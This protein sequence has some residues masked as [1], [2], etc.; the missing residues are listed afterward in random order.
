MFRNGPPLMR[1]SSPGVSRMRIGE[2]SRQYKR[3]RLSVAPFVEREREMDML[4]DF[5]AR[6][7]PARAP[8]RGAP[9]RP[10]ALLAG[11]RVAFEP[12][13]MPALVARA[14]H[15]ARGG[16]PPPGGD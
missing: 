16:A 7:E 2:L 9:A 1:C 11:A 14:D 12:L 5:V 6:A 13:G 15:L 4:L 3:Y 8:A 10:P